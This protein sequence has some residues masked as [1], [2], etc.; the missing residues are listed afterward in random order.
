M[1]RLL[2]LPSSL[3]ALLLTM[4]A[5]ACF[6]AVGLAPR[7]ASAYSYTF[8]CGPSWPSLP[9]DYWINAAGSADIPFNRVVDIVDDSFLAWGE[10]CCSNF[11][12]NYRGTTQLTAY[13]NQGRIVLSWTEDAWD[14]QWG[15]VNSVIGITFLSVYNNCTI[16]E[17]PIIFNGVGFRFTDG[18][19]GTDLQSIAT[20]EIGH[21]L[22][23]GHSNLESATMY[24]AYIGG[25][26]ARS[27]HQDD[28]NGVCSLYTQSCS[29]TTSAQ[30]SGGQQCIGGQCRKPPCTSDAMCD[31]GL[32]CVSGDCVVPPCSSDAECGAGFICEGNA[33]TSSCPV[34]RRRCTS[35]AD[36][37]S[38]GF[39]VDDGTG[40]SVCI[41]LC[42]ENAECPG[43]AVCYAVGDGQ[44]GEVY[45]CGAPNATT[46]LC[47]ADYVCQDNSTDQCTS[48]SDC[49]NGRVCQN[50]TDGRRCVQND[51][52][53]NVTCG[54]G[55]VC[56][57]GLCIDDGSSNNIPGN[58]TPGNNT[59]GNNTPGQNNEPGTG[60]TGTQPGQDDDDDILVIW[61]DP[62]TGCSVGAS[63]KSQS[64]WLAVAAFGAL[65]V[66]RRRK[67]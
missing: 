18:P 61:Q 14:P 33:C 34:C 47:P 15:S 2:C 64:G 55:L 26:G 36:C 63:G 23:L 25:T 42:G 21:L 53:A 41:V 39:C 43:D 56:S 49:T 30:C 35:E 20:H 17:A 16:A 51:P 12:A 11:T 45:A 37:G 58:N 52:C 27:L 57:N 3:R 24:A 40:V 54:P 38:G 62:E 28:I 59:P 9:V 6:V 46:E 29:C 4:I 66:A 5:T 13:N 22:G 60:G 32:A 31:T 8:S 19:N 1:R 48:N 67:R 44:G 65:V 7:A 50:T 10:P